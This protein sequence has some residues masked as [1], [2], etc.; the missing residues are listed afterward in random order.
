MSLT[1]MMVGCSAGSDDGSGS[2][3][4]DVIASVTTT[5]TCGDGTKK[6]L[7]QGATPAQLAAAC[8]DPN[9]DITN[10]QSCPAAPMK[11]RLADFFPNGT[12]T[13]SLSKTTTIALFQ[14][15]VNAVGTGQWKKEEVQTSGWLGFD[16]DL[17][18]NASLFMTLAA[19]KPDV[20]LQYMQ[21]GLKFHVD[22][23]GLLSLSAAEAKSSQAALFG[24]ANCEVF[25]DGSV[26]CDNASTVRTVSVNDVRNEGSSGKGW[27]GTV[28]KKCVRLAMSTTSNDHKTERMFVIFAKQP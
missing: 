8:P 19:T 3:S 14:R 2:G 21:D 4:A 25:L 22:S 6:E 15:P 18:S 13:A 7:P 27:T 24:I 10:P 17:N 26:G 12:N 23:S 20:R 5:V 1:T 16:D 9:A 11:D 28:G